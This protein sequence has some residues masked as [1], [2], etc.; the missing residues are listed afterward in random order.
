[1]RPSPIPIIADRPE[2]IPGTIHVWYACVDCS[3]IE[4]KEF[5]AVLS[6]EE[7]ARAQRFRSAQDRDRHIVQHGLLRSLLA[8]YL[9]CAARQVHIRTSAHGKPCIEGKD[10]EGSLQFSLSHSGAYAAFAFNRCDSIGVDIE[11]VREIPEMEE[12]VAQHFTPREKAEMLACPI[13]WKL[14]TFYRLWTRKEAVLKAQGEGLLKAIDCVDVAT[15]E[16][17]G[18]WKVFIEEGSA[19][20]E[21]SVTDIEGPPGFAA[22]VAV[23]GFR[24]QISIQPYALYQCVEATQDVKLNFKE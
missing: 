1:M 8:G 22:A 9:G 3:L 13:D 18:H 12:I 24:A 6:A 19:V 23:A 10:A 20:E 5:S 4:I 17:P 15:G 21:Y 14:K 11:E 16:D 2:L 7:T